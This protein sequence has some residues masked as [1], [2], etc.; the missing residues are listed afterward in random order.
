MLSR[1]LS[2]VSAEPEAPALIDAATGA[3][4]TRAALLAMG[5]TLAARLTAADIREGDAVAIQLPNSPDFV[6]AF[7]AVLQ[8]RLVAVP[9]DRD[10][11]ESEVAA[12][13]SHFAVKALVY[14]GEPGDRILVRTIREGAAL[15]VEARLL[16]LTSGST[17]KP[18]G[19]VT[20]EGNLIA[21]CEQ[22][23][24]TM[25]IRPDDVNFGAIPLSHSYGFSN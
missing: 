1:F 19:I 9:I 2:L 4:T 16:K 3:V 10:A 8:L 21:D 24:S 17:G 12:I 18:K 13:L 15:P 7:L 25:D 20:S 5:Q 14:R 6:A 22:I 23:C 11:R